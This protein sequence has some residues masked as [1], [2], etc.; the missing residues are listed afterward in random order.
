M[1]RAGVSEPA[2]FSCLDFVIPFFPF[3]SKSFSD[4][5]MSACPHGL[6]A[7]GQTICWCQP[8]GEVLSADI[9]H[10]GSLCGDGQRWPDSWEPGDGE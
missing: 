5:V 9:S 1:G 4:A 3:G 10:L 6:N 7:W 2:F 8:F